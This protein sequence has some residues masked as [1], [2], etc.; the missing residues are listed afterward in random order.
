MSELVISAANFTIQP[1]VNIRNGSPVE[2]R[3]WYNRPFLTSEGIQVQGGGGTS[4]FRITTP[5]SV[6]DGLITVEQDT[7]LWTTDDAQDT[8]PLSILL[9]AAIYSRGRLIQQ[10]QIASKPQWIVPSSL[11]PTTT[12]AEF[13]NYNQATALY[14]Y[15]PN[16]Y[17][18]PQTDAQIRN[19]SATDYASDT[20]LGNVYTSVEPAIANQPVA[21]ITDDPLVRDAVSIEGV[22]VSPTPPLDGQVLVFNEANNQYEPGNQ[23]AGF[24]N[25][26]SNEVGSALPRV[27]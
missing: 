22:A 1:L 11:A 2:L 15:N 17:N 16:Y 25:V 5:C 27:W 9:S 6:A 10:L 24:G 21:W 13:S 18:A 26:I 8:S 20:H 12:W 4:G 14:Y 7:L 19:F 23:A 3:W